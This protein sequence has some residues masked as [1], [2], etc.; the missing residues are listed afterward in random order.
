MAE[1]V[2][3]PTRG[4]SIRLAA[5]TR[6]VPTA[7]RQ[8]TRDATQGMRRPGLFF[9]ERDLVCHPTNM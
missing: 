7:R 4:L 6:E 8:L 2:L 1:S 9:A 5:V 3:A